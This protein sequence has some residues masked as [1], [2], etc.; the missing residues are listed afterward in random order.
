MNDIFRQS[1]FPIRRRE[2]SKHIIFFG[3]VKKLR[4]SAPPLRGHFRL[5]LM[6]IADVAWLLVYIFPYYPFVKKICLSRKNHKK[7]NSTCTLFTSYESF[8]WFG[9]LYN[10]KVS[11]FDFRHK[12]GGLWKP[13]L[14][15]FSLSKESLFWCDIS[16]DIKNAF[17]PFLFCVPF[18]D[19]EQPLWK[20]VVA[21][22]CNQKTGAASIMKL[23]KLS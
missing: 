21:S 11:G 19:Y 4:E 14:C 9:G 12:G 8:E 22:E 17:W 3:E 20:S 6:G 18:M 2:A 23:Q 1:R 13:F 16:I 5:W 15:S 10:C 7:A